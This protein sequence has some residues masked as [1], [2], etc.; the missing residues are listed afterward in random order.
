VLETTEKLFFKAWE[1]ACY[2]GF[3]VGR[4]A[5]RH[6]APR[7]RGSI[8]FTGATASI[9]GGSGFAAFA[10]AKFG[11]RAVAQS[12]ARELGPKNIHV[13]HL[14][15]DAGVDSEAIHQRMRA[16]GIDAKDIAA[17]SLT[18]TESIAEAN[19]FAHHQARDGWTHELDLRP[20]VEKW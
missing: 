13:V 1:L 7:G 11:L 5:A 14:L 12:M 6:M 19:W 16:R 20:F 18:K 2:A 17:D 4:E 15:I 10:A 8:L 9:R 3:L